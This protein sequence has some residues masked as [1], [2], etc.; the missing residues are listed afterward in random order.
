MD[1]RPSFPVS[2]KATLTC[3]GNFV[4]EW[5]LVLL[6]LAYQRRTPRTPQL[7]NPIHVSQGQR[8]SHYSVCVEKQAVSGAPKFEAVLFHPLAGVQSHFGMQESPGLESFRV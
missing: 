4:L 5:P 6:F 2:L 8:Q 3:F 1:A 7:T